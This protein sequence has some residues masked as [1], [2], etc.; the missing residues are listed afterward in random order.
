MCCTTKPAQSRSIRITLC[1]IMLPWMA[2]GMLKNKVKLRSK[3][4][5]GEEKLLRSEQIPPFKST[6]RPEYRLIL[7]QENPL[8]LMPFLF[9]YLV[10]VGRAKFYV[11][12]PFS[13]EKQKTKPFAGETKARWYLE[14]WC[15]LGLITSSM[16]ISIMKGIND[17]INQF[18]NNRK[19]MHLCI[20]NLSY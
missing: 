18:Y 3:T 4:M 10:F 13:E 1:N 17:S 6:C 11:K 15:C 19:C 7:R 20:T 12:A 5:R 8:V 14:F 9:C 16:S 2:L